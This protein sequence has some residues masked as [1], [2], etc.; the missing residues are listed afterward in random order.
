VR[1]DDEQ[2]GAEEPPGRPGS[3]S[4]CLLTDE[5]VV[6][7]PCARPGCAGRVRVL[8]TLGPEGE[9]H[10]PLC[11]RAY[12]Y[13]L[14]RLDSTPAGEASPRSGVRSWR[15]RYLPCAEEPKQTLLTFVGHR[16]IE[17][18]PGDEFALIQQ[19]EDRAQNVFRN[20][21]LGREWVVQPT[22]G[23]FPVLGLA[24]LVACWWVL[25]LAT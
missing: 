21:T 20:V 9:V 11:R 23:C 4:S 1:P 12:F 19:R 14:G 17:V 16:D 25:A 24:L 13:V 2:A 7:L 3:A 10:C 6:V 8:T 22:T 5:A 15:L 18:G